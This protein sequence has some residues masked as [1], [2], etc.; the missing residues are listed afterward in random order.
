MRVLL[1]EN[2]PRKL[3]RLL[4]GCDVHMVVDMGWRGLTNGRLLR[5]AVDAGF[6]RMVTLDRNMQHQQSLPDRFGVVVAPFNDRNRIGGLAPA[7][8]AA[9]SACPDGGFLIMPDDGAPE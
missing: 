2:M 1:D 5:A 6:S 3:V 7:I 9:L 8:L 4:A